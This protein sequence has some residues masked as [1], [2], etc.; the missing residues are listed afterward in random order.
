MSHDNLSARTEEISQEGMIKKDLKQRV[1]FVLQ[2]HALRYL[3]FF[4]F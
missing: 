3:P 1:N 2:A 4:Q